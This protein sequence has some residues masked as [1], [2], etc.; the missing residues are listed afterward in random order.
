MN[1]RSSRRKIIKD[2]LAGS[3]VLVTGTQLL[4]S[5]VTK[6]KS[7]DPVKLKGNINHSVCRWC[8]DSIPFE[9]FCVSVKGIGIPAIDLVAP[10]DWPLLQK[11]DLYSS[12]CY[13]AGPVSLTDGF[14][15]TNFHAKLVPQ[16]LDVIPLMVKAGYK[17]VICFMKP[18]D[19]R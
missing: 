18:G 19:G 7:K 13:P 4:S 16:Y 17:D 9:E 10:K 5:Y 3:A 6:P 8:F 15:E 2:I 1:H 11:Y 12:M 14:A